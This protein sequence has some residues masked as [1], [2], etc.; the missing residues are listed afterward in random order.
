MA[1]SDSSL[2]TYLIGTDEE[3]KLHNKNY[4]AENGY[5]Y[6]FIVHFSWQGTFF[7]PLCLYFCPPIG[8]IIEADFFYRA[9]GSETSS[10][11]IGKVR[12]L[13]SNYH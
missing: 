10:G 13:Y 3:L 6:D 7:G 2:L 1:I 12:E 8:V 9:G 5:E 4:E 11:L